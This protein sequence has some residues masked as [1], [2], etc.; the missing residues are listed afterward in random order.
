MPL[1]ADAVTYA[2]SDA[3]N[4]WLVYEALWPRACAE[5]LGSAVVAM[6]ERRACDFRDCKDGRERWEAAMAQAKERRREAKEKTPRKAGEAAGGK[7][8]AAAAAG[9]KAAA[10][11]RAGEGGATPERRE[12]GKRGRDKPAAQKAGPPGKVR[13]EACGID[14]DDVAAQARDLP[15]ISQRSLLRTDPPISA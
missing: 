11:A 14:M 9:P 1:S 8:A 13:C 4:T 15:T 10:A 12:R 7:G 6:S 5:G 2:A 3:W